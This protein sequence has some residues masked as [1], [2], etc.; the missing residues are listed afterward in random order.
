MLTA[1]VV[2]E[3]VVK[4]AVLM[5]YANHCVN[6]FVYAGLNSDYRKAFKKILQK[7]CVNVFRSRGSGGPA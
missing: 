4:I 2:P 1:T 7:M 6:V 5:I 3:A